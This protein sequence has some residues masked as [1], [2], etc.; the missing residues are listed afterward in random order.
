MENND[1]FIADLLAD[2]ILADA[3]PMETDMPAGRAYRMAGKRNY[4]RMLQAEHLR[5]S[6]PTPPAAGESVHIV[7]NAK[8]DFATWIP[9]IIDWAGSADF[10][11][12]S[13]WTLSRPN[14]QEIFALHDDEKIAKGQLHFLTGLYF[15]RREAA[16]YNMLLQGL[17]E[18]GGR[19]RAFEN[20]CKVLLL[21]NASKDQ[22]ITVEGS[23]NLNANPRFEQYVVTN[24]RGLLEFH[25]SWM[26]DVF[27]SPPKQ[28]RSTTTR[29]EAG[30][31]HAGY[32]HRRAG[33]GVTTATNSPSDRRNILRTKA[34][35]LRD[36]DTL[37]AFAAD[38][39]V[40]IRHWLP[41]PPPGTVVTA[42]PQG[43]SWPG[44]YFAESLAAETARIIGLPYLSLIARTDEKKHHHPMV[45]L[46]QAPFAYRD[47]TALP[48]PP[49]V[50]VVDDIITSGTTMKNSL[51]ALAAAG[52]PAYGFAY[53]GA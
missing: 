53:N 20:H 33:L 22:F 39:A 36:A 12:C 14:A 44:E 42:P 6:M 16:T 23:A 31:S 29:S 18:R 27:T 43:A 13:T 52:I 46:R 7:S 34:D 47:D 15:K 37:A 51:A 10:L 4:L 2:S 35:P 40:L 1:D 24:D 5:D 49:T 19:F 11:Y 9:T 38:V 41:T 26:E 21:A 32:S 8:H 50:I 45:A 48:Q 17:V 28:Y 3:D 30:A 25:R